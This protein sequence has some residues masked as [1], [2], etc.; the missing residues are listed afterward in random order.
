MR[1]KPKKPKA[2]GTAAQWKQYDERMKKWK[3]EKAL[4]ERLKKKYQ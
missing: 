2:S 4:I 1:A 3:A